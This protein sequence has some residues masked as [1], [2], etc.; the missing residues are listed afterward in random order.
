[1]NQCPNCKATVNSDVKFCKYCATD[2]SQNQ[3]AILVSSSGPTA[4]TRACSICGASLKENSKYCANC[5]APIFGR[6]SDNIPYGSSSSNR[7]PLI[8]GGLVLATLLLAGGIT[9]II[10]LTGSRGTSESITGRYSLVRSS[11]S[12]LKNSSLELRNDNSFT[13]TLQLGDY[14][15]M[16]G[17]YIVSGDTIDFY[18]IQG[19]SS[20]RIQM[21][22]R[23]RNRTITITAQEKGKTFEMEYSKE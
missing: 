13:L 19:T 9:T 3:Q 23:W 15:E 17:K 2:L 18:N 12:R 11:I 10:L 8:I 5:A 7:K 16:T 1:M 6:V 22:G 21:S 14:E 4:P 20:S